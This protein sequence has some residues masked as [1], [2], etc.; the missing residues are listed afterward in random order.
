M[1]DFKRNL[2]QEVK[3][4]IAAQKQQ[5]AL[6]EKYDVPEDVKIIEKSNMGKFMLRTAGTITR[7]IATII[8]IILAVIGVV[9]L[10]YPDSRDC[11]FVIYNQTIDQI[12]AFVGI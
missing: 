4:E 3:E 10:I 1:A 2:V 11:L 9:A 7:I 12:K 5:E 8:V 6:H